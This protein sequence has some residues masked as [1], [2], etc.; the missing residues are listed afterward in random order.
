MPEHRSRLH[1]D[2]ALTSVELQARDLAVLRDLFYYRFATTPALMRTAAW[3]TGGSGMQHF[4][5]RLTDLWRAG[6][7]SRSDAGTRRYLHG[8]RPFIYTIES[9]KAASAARMG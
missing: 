4:A 1:R 3:A 9:G 6:Y 5:K 7:V 8:S 2:P